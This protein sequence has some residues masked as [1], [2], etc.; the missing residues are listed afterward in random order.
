[1][2]LLALP[3][4]EELES[5]KYYEIPDRIVLEMERAWEKFCEAQEAVLN[6]ISEHP[7]LVE[8][9]DIEVAETKRILPPG[10]MK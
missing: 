2:E 9:E 1:V 4:K 5:G 10:V 3:F 6:Y 7:M 8:D